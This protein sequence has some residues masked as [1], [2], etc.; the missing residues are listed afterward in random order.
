MNHLKKNYVSQLLLSEDM[1]KIAVLLKLKGPVKLI[2]KLTGQGGVVEDD[3]T[4]EAAAS[5]ETAE[6]SGAKIAP[7][8]WTFIGYAEYPDATVTFFAAMTDLSQ[9][10]TREKEPIMVLD[11]ATLKMIAK[12]NPNVV[13]EDL[14]PLL[15]RYESIVA[16]QKL[17]K[18]PV[19]TPLS[20]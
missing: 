8:E 7:H 4:V 2:G 3:E 16:A 11:V 6:E 5:R 12:V 10:R 17:Q 13:A 18:T 14:I 9:V 15:E 1:T 20:V 19:A